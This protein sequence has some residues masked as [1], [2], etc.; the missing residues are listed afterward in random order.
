MR[1]VQDER[2]SSY[3]NLFPIDVVSLRDR[4]EREENNS[5]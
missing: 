4:G 1:L 3:A 5:H 2:D